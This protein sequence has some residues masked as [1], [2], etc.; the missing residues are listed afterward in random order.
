MARYPASSRER[1]MKAE[2]VILR[3]LSKQIAFWQAAR[4][5]QL[6]A[7]YRVMRSASICSITTRRRRRFIQRPHRLNRDSVRHTD[8]AQ[9]PRARYSS[10]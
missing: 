8:A 2:E 9:T 1:A 6:A 7:R 3:A 10:M 5:V 4:K